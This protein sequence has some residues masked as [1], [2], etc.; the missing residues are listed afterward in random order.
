MDQGIGS[1]DVRTKLM[2]AIECKYANNIQGKWR[3]NFSE[4]IRGITDRIVTIYYK[5]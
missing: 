2:G 1:K 4:K 3:V 5:F